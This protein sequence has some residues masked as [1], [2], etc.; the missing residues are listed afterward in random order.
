MTRENKNLLRGLA[1]AV[2][3]GVAVYS[4][5]LQMTQ[6]TG[7]RQQSGSLVGQPAPTFELPSARG[8]DQT[9]LAGLEGKGVVL[10][11]WA[12][13]CKSCL[14]ELPV[15]EQI[16]RDLGGED[17]AVVT[18]AGDD[19]RAVQGFLRAHR[20]A[21]PV[22]LDDG[23]VHLDY[24]VG[25]LPRTVFIGP[26][27]KILADVA[28]PVSPPELRENARRLAACAR[29]ARSGASTADAWCA[30]PGA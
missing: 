24:D 8:G 23:R 1:L 10:A 9:S 12:T 25:Q 13:W 29:A 6:M 18:V 15:L 11:F 26:D 20:Y 27:G 22:L 16:H 19:P 21:L 4:I 30:G 3:V 28:G 2:L 5:T 7:A 17:L 14:Q